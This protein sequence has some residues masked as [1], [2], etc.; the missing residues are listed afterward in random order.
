LNRTC[1]QRG[2]RMFSPGHEPT[3]APA[4]RAAQ[5]LPYHPERRPMFK[6]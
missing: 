2:D 1:L 5:S 6:Q 3:D 4:E